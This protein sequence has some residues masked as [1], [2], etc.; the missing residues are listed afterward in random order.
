MATTLR[1]G[2]VLFNDGSAQSTAGAQSAA[3]TGYVKLPGGIIFQWGS[4]TRTSG[5]STLNF[6]IAFPNACLQAASSSGDYLE[7]ISSF[8]TTQITLESASSYNVPIRYIAVGY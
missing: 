4:V 7:R 6:P 5:A 2:D 3:A 1:S 8:S